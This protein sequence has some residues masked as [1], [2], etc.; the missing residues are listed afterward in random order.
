VLVHE[1][2]LG[3]QPE[4]PGGEKYSTA[5]R[6]CSSPFSATRLDL[7]ANEITIFRDRIR[8]DVQTATPGL[9]FEDAWARRE[10]MSYQGQPFQVVSRSDL[11]SSKTAAGRDVD[12]EDVRLLKLTGDGEKE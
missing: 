10:T 5:C 3:E 7:L 1:P 9:R 2:R 6:P 4:G 12:L 8:I 11:I